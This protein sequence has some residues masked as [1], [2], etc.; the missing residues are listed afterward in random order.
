MLWFHHQNA[1]QNH[2]VKTANRSLEN[3][4]QLKYLERTVTNLIWN[5]MEIEG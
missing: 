5:Q 4:T 2:H 1:R 3:I